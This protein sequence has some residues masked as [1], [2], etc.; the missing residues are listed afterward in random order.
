MS[1]ESLKVIGNGTIRKPGYGFLFAFH[2]NYRRIL[3]VS[4]Q[5]TNVT[6][7]QTDTAPQ[8]QPH[9]QPHQSAVTR[10]IYCLQTQTCL[11]TKS[12]LRLTITVCHKQQYDVT[13]SVCSKSTVCT[14]GMTIARPVFKRLT[15]RCH[16]RALWPNGA[17]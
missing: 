13:R 16:A 15:L 8:Q 10:Q 12:H 6:D 9:L 14:N 2:S 4:T 11:E 17:S 3:A 7:R 1:S 5:Y